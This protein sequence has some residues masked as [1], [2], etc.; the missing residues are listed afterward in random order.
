M[1]QLKLIVLGLALMAVAAPALALGPLGINAEVALNSKYVWRGQT[2]APDPVL[3]PGL[4]VSFLGF[5]LGAWGNM[6]T[7]DFNGTKSQFNEID[8]TLSYDLALPFI[9]AGAGAIYYDFPNTDFEATAEVYIYASVNVIL[10]PKVIVFQDVDTYKGAYWELSIGHGFELSPGADLDL[11]GGLGLGSKSYLEGY[12][13]WT[14][15][16]LSNPNQVT[17]FTGASMSNFYITASLPYRAF[18]F[19]TFTPMISYS[20]LMGDAKDAVNATNEDNPRSEI[21]PDAFVFGMKISFNF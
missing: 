13:G 11:T 3:Q 20:S 5:G 2:L 15:G 12:F 10:S 18:P 8:Y 17:N 9:S 14:G 1:K 19:F 4:K 7:S 16:D 21:D 6:D